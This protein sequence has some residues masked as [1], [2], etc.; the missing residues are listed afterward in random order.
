MTLVSEDTYWR[1]YW[2]DSGSPQ[3]RPI[4]IHTS[5]KDESAIKCC[6]YFF[7]K[8]GWTNLHPSLLYRTHVPEVNISPKISI[9]AQPLKMALHKN[10]AMHGS[11]IV[12]FLHESKKTGLFARLKALFLHDSK[13]NSLKPARYHIIHCIFF[14]F[15]FLGTALQLGLVWSN[16][17]SRG[18]WLDNT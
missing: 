1:R 16:L 15:V 18:A 2:C 9:S 10:P 4:I 11:R 8:V 13:V 17:F 3:S 7:K 14:Y 12:I 5:C 6:I